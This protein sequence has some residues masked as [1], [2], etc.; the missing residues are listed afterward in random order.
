MNPVDSTPIIVH[1]EILGKFCSCLEV[2]KS[3]R[4]PSNSWQRNFLIPSK[5]AGEPLTMAQYYVFL[6]DIFFNLVAVLAADSSHYSSGRNHKRNLTC[7]TD[8]GKILVFLN[9]FPDRRILAHEAKDFDM[10][11]SSLLSN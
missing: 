5:R 8:E 6:T 3:F 1:P 11:R 7:Q 4:A 2:E 10:R 9:T